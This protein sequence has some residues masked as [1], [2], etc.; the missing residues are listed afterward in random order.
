[1]KT[2]L[3]TGRANTGISGRSAFTLMELLAVIGIIAI[4]AAIVVGAVGGATTSSKLKRVEASLR[5]IETAIEAYRSAFGSYPPDNPNNPA[6]PPLYYELVGTTTPSANPGSSFTTLDQRE[7]ISS[8]DA[9]TYLGV[10]GFVN[11]TAA[12]GFL[13]NLNPKKYRQLPGISADVELL[14]APIEGAN[15]SD[16]KFNPWRYVSRNPTNNPGKF[17]LW[18]EVRI[19]GQIRVIGNW[20]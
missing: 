3:K 17:D 12:K 4:L 19:G 15:A 11:S 10:P 6:Q 16:P 5:E 14:I 7:S 1:M 13:K 9:Q 18:A 2:F 8:A 20:K